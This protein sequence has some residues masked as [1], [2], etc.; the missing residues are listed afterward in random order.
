MILVNLDTIWQDFDIFWHDLTR[1]DMIWYDLKWFWNDLFF[2]W[3]RLFWNKHFFEKHVI[4]EKC[5]FLKKLIFSSKCRPGQPGIDRD[6]SHE[7][8]DGLLVWG[9]PG[10]RSGT[11]LTEELWSF[12]GNCWYFPWFWKLFLLKKCYFWKNV[13]LLKYLIFNIILKILIYLIKIS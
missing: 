13:I 11:L 8:R 4:F 3:R 10:M 9:T 7:L 12:E 2:F 5:H 6:L 1:F